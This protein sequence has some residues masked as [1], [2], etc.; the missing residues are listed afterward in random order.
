MFCAVN[1]WAVS[2]ASPYKGTGRNGWIYLTSSVNHS[3][4]ATGIAQTPQIAMSSVSRG[5]SAGVSSRGIVTGRMSTGMVMGTAVPVRGIY[6]SATS[7][8]GGVTTYSH[9]HLG[10]VRKESEDPSNPSHHGQPE[11]CQQCID[12]NGDDVCDRC[13]C[14]MDG[15]TC[16]TEEG[17]PGYC[18]CPLDMNWGAM[19]F[20]ALL[21]GGYAMWK[22][23]S[24]YLT[25]PIMGRDAGI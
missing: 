7:V 18:W 5:V 10:S 3:T 22:K 11:I 6:T 21:A 23:N 14:D 15:C 4:A 13:R 16:A 25:S 9:P 19:L 20:L 12:A 8:T 24:P 2:Y 1:V 17:G